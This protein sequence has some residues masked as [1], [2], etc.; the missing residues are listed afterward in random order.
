MTAA[1]KNTSPS[2]D[3]GEVA[4]FS[5]LADS[6]WDPK[7]PFRP[8]HVLNP[9]RLSYLVEQICAQFGRSPADR[10]PFKG[11]SLLDI[12]C[13]GGLL[14]EPMARLGATVT[15]IDAAEKNIAVAR[16]HA[17]KSGLN[18]DYQAISA[19][20]L[21][22]RGQKF[23]IILTLEVIEHVAD[24]QSFLTAA[25]TLLAPAGLMILSTLNRTPKAF[26]LAII[27]AEYVMRWLPRGTHDWRKFLTPDELA[28]HVQQAGLTA[29]DRMG[30]TYSPLADRW[31]TSARDLSVNYMITAHHAPSN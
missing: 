18:I 24:I 12:G 22:N 27:G 2:I 21:A 13:G 19:E 14:A 6:W 28:A 1:Q 4:N 15:G 31:S 16:L 17:E 25:S 8:L 9:A 30:L 11:L 5:A 29:I 26:M 10:L 7:G 20:D 23:D 3:P